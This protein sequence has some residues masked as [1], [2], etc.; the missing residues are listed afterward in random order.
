MSE[1][2]NHYKFNTEKIIE[3]SSNI[4]PINILK[5]FENYNDEMTISQVV[6]F[7]ERQGITFTKTMIQNYVRVGLLPPPIDRRYYIKNHLILLTVIYS[8]KDVFS[9]EEIG[10][11]FKPI[12]NDSNTFD[13]DIIDMGSIYNEY[14]SLYEKTIKDFSNSIPSLLSRVCDT[15]NTFN[16]KEEDKDS[17]SFFLTVLT[18]MTQSIVTKELVKLINNINNNED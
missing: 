18:L 11:I 15:T 17:V 6:R 7:F 5:N 10:N 14:I 9:L 1:L 8:L 16:I 3:L 13:D 12:M 2:D 4:K